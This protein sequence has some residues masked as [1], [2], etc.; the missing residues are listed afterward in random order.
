[1]AKQASAK[2]IVWAA[3]AAETGGSGNPLPPATF[4]PSERVF[5]RGTTSGNLRITTTGAGRVTTESAT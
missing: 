5:Y 4:P 3:I 2:M 1:M